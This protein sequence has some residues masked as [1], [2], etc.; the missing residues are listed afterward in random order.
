MCALLAASLVLAGCGRRDESLA[1]KAG[2]KVG[3]T[4]T[5]FG[6]GIGAGVDSALSIPVEVGRSA[7]DLGLS[8][9]VSKWEGRSLSVYVIAKEPT[10]AALVAKAYNRA[11]DEIGR[12]K[13]EA[14]FAKDDAKY[15]KFDFAPEMDSRLVVRCVIDLP[16]AAPRGAEVVGTVG[17]SVRVALPQLGPK[18][19]AE[20]TTRAIRT[21]AEAGG[22]KPQVDFVCHAC[23][24]EGTHVGS[25]SG[26]V[27]SGDLAS[28]DAP[29]LKMSV[30]P[31]VFDE[32]RVRYE[33]DASWK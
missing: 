16:S 8:K 19:Y 31:T 30:R 18:C 5:D 7:A 27:I 15:L 14:A 1:K 4:I 3:E 32:K 10:S 2:S 25:V 9:T 22:N 24:D 12:S 17:G 21:A 6:S 20:I 13:V 11:G 23:V 28:V 26:W 29:N 33:V